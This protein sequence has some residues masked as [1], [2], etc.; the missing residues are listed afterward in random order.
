M[1]VELAET[2]DAEGGR[3]RTAEV[4]VFDVGA[5]GI[6]RVAVYLQQSELTS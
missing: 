4:V 6:E 5:V 2:V 3:L 1:A